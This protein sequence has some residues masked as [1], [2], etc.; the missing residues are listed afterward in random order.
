MKSLIVFLLLSF[1]IYAAAAPICKTKKETKE[2][3]TTKAGLTGG[4][5]KNCKKER[6]SQVEKKHNDKKSSRRKSGATPDEP[7]VSF[8]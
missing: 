1:V 3:V 8:P 2:A 7:L 6:E 5:S 4:N